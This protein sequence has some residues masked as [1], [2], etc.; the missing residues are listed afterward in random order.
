M[1]GVSSPYAT[2]L[3]ELAADPAAAGGVRVYRN[4]ATGKVRVS[5][6]TT[7]A[8]VGGDGSKVYRAIINQSGTSAP[9]ATVV[10]NSLGAIVWSRSGAGLYRATLTNAFTVNKTFIAPNSFTADTGDTISIIQS[11]ASIITIGT[12][13]DDTLNALM[14]EILVYP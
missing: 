14:F 3:R 12:S 1:S 10:V 13:A 11:S 9:V 7:W 4:T 6:G 2:R 8:D 5:N